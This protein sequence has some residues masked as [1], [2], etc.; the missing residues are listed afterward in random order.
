MPTTGHIAVEVCELIMFRWHVSELLMFMVVFCS[1]LPNNLS[2]VL[3]FLGTT[4]TWIRQFAVNWV[5]VWEVRGKMASAVQRNHIA[6][7]GLN[8]VLGAWTRISWDLDL[9]WLDTDTWK[10]YCN[11]QHWSQI[12]IWVVA[13]SARSE[14]FI[15]H[16]WVN[17]SKAHSSTRL[18]F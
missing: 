2:T 6:A 3:H 17:Y 14:Y 9:F 10:S 13:K 15:L 4:E 11:F 8:L 1:K 12:G 18:I 5:R 16:L 7:S